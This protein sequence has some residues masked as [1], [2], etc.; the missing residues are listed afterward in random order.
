MVN[1]SISPSSN[2]HA[3][4]VPPWYIEIK[5]KTQKIVGSP[6]FVFP[7]G[8]LRTIVHITLTLKT[9]SVERAEGI[10]DFAEGKISREGF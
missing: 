3:S 7:C 2:P 1:P 8:Y 5:L 6:P 10:R 4:I 9:S